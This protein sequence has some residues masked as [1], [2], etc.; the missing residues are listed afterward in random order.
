MKNK[1]PRIIKNF[2]KSNNIENLTLGNNYLKSY[3]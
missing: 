1:V 3:R 2:V